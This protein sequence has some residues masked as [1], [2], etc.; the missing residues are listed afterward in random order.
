MVETYFYQTGRMTDTTDYWMGFLVNNGKTTDR[1]GNVIGT[2]YNSSDSP[3][4]HYADY[5]PTINYAVYADRD[6]RYYRY[7]W[8]CVAGSRLP[9]CW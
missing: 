4:L 2:A 3:Y 5:Q 6:R 1:E 9:G 8:W 7:K